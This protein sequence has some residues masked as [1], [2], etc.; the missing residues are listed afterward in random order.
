MCSFM[1]IKKIQH[2]YMHLACLHLD[3][4]YYVDTKVS[5]TTRKCAL[6]ADQNEQ[7]MK[8]A[9]KNRKVYEKEISIK[10]HKE[11]IEF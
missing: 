1:H 6:Q 10:E 5:M 4:Q 2:I 8:Q 7:Q 3:T 11:L 9:I